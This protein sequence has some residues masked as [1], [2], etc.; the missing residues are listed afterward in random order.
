MP[1]VD[2]YLKLA[3]SSFKTAEAQL[4]DAEDSLQTLV[5]RLDNCL[6]LMKQIPRDE[7][8]SWEQP[9]AFEQDQPFNIKASPPVRR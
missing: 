5:E 6:K 7:T 1:E 2:E 3:A 8:L 4:G 9:G